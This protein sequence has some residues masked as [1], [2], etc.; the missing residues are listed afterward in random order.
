MDPIVLTQGSGE[1][2]VIDANPVTSTGRP[3]QVP[4]AN[5][6]AVMTAGANAVLV[7]PGPTP[8]EVTVSVKPGLAPFFGQIEGNLQFR[9]QPENFA[10]EIIENVAITVVGS[11]PDNGKLAAFN[12]QLV[13]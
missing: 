1:T 2:K 5:F 7:Q 11:E 4:V 8:Y 12:P 3:V 10:E 6:Q 9:G 13:A